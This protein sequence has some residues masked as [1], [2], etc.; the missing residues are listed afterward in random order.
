[1]MN[2]YR[3]RVALGIMGLLGASV[4]V[5]II[6]TAS[7]SSG[8]NQCSGA[9]AQ[10]AECNGSPTAITPPT[11]PAVKESPWAS[12]GSS[13]V[14]PNS[15]I[16]FSS[17][18]QGWIIAN[19]GGG[20]GVDHYVSAGP[21]NEIW[22][23][24][25]VEMT[26]NGGETWSNVLDVPTGIWGLDVLNAN[27]IWAVG[28]NSLY[29]STNGGIKWTAVQENES[30]DSALLDVNFVS[31]VEGFGI[32]TSGDVVFTTDGGRSWVTPAALPPSLVN[33]SDMCVQGGS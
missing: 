6:E 11:L 18:S 1:M 14:L 27:Y 33:A 9:P 7:N 15:S 23:G 4:W 3:I 13:Q 16:A 21:Q 30:A 12:F 26:N 29:E 19:V 17:Q 2:K 28:V 5:G 10:I 20:P 24:T 31:S 25:G 32:N 22:P 8:A